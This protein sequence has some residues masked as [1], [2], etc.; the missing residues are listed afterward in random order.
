VPQPSPSLLTDNR[1]VR[2]RRAVGAL[3]TLALAL[4][5]CSGD[6]GGGTQ[7]AAAAP[8]TG[9]RGGAAGGPVG[10][11]GGAPTIV[12]SSSDV[13]TARRGPIEVTTAITGDL[14]PVETVEVRA[15]LEGDLVG[16]F[17]N[18]GDRV[19]AGQLLARFEASEQES[20][21][22]SAEAERAAAEAALTTAQWNAEQS[23]ELFK[24]GAIPERDYK[25]TE[26][27]VIAARARLAA[28][29]ARVRST[30]SVVTD[31]RVLSPVT[32]IVERRL[33]QNGERVAP[34]TAMFSVV[35]NEVLE[36]AASVPGRQAGE[37]RPGQPVRFTADGR[38][39]EGTVARVSPTI[40]PS[41]RA[42]TVYTRIPNP[43]GTLK[44]NTFA[45]GRI[46]GRTV[47]GALVVPSP[48]LRQSGE[49]GESFVYRL[50]GQTIER[51][52]VRLGVVDEGAGIA[53][54]LEGLS[55][56]DRVIVGNVGTIGS[57]MRVQ[58]VGEGP[59]Q[60][61][62]AGQGQGQAPRQ[63][64]GRGEGRQQ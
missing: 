22:R 25:V 50:A 28:A 36:L 29:E 35:R 64:Q 6:K 8:A 33:V 4:S 44:G 17:V 16:V 53:Q 13:S 24:A 40:D 52:P 49:G 59:G 10:P 51:T 14:R 2:T 58:V 31:T 23:A 18:E 48:A 39:F 55:E 45:T 37:I 34:G 20:N 54:V 30:S 57:G 12:L 47:D 7:T 56:G 43:G 19:R 27:E 46:I 26:Q 38:A 42:L 63:G 32:G 21:S 3:A 5:A 11:G 9:A 1:P 60:P 41:T 61:A 15:R 62:P